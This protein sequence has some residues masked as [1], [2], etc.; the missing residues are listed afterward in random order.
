MLQTIELTRRRIDEVGR[1]FAADEGDGDGSLA[2]GRSAHQEYFARNG[3][4]SPRMPLCCECLGQVQIG[5]YRDTLKIFTN[6]I[7]SIDASL[8]PLQDALQG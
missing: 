7:V 1:A 2:Y 3:G 5:P 4:F 8:R 6:T